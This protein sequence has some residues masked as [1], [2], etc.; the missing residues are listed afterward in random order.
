MFISF[1]GKGGSSLYMKVAGK[2]LIKGHSAKHCKQLSVS[3]SGVARKHEEIF[4]GTVQNLNRLNQL[5]DTT[6]W[7]D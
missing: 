5:R 2:G 7:T 6:P 3:C 4:G 1:I